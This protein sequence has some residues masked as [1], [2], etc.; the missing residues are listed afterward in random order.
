MKGQLHEDELAEIPA[1]YT[2]EI[3]PI[4]VPFLHQTRHLIKIC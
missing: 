3:I 2:V 4:D 1:N